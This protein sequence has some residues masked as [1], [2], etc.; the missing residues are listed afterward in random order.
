MNKESKDISRKLKSPVENVRKESVKNLLLNL[1]PGETL[2]LDKI[3]DQGK[4][5]FYTSHGREAINLEVL[6]Y[7]LK[8]TDTGKKYICVFF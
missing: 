7:R 3:T 6:G 5:V 8:E 2:I 1:F 4:V